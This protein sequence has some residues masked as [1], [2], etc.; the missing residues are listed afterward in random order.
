LGL[1]RRVV[2]GCR[3]V[4]GLYRKRELAQVVRE[5]TAV[6]DIGNEV[7]QA[8]KP[9]DQLKTDPEKARET[10]TFAANVC[11]ALA[12]YLWPIVP[13]FAEAAARGLGVTIARMDA[14]LLFAERQRQLGTFER[15]FERIERRQTDAVVEASKDSLAA[16]P[17]PAG[18][19]K[20]TP[21]PAGVRAGVAPAT[22]TAGPSTAAS[23]PALA[24]PTAAATLAVAA[25]TTA[26]TTATMTT[27]TT[28]LIDYALFSKLDLRVGVVIKAEAVP[29]SKKLLRLEVDLGEATLRQIVAGIALSYEPAA[30]VGTRI[31]VVANLEPVRLMGVES[32][33]M[34]L[35]AGEAPALS[36]LRL[37]RE[38]PPGTKVK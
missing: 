5:L 25:A 26:T 21:K 29:K 31:V 28:G 19:A 18:N 34:V 30:L 23:K 27:P 35:A 2:A 20:A 7:M 24:P 38:L 3:R 12:M 1:A 32:R 22:T 9:W 37:E 14:S 16:A 11:Y 10:L 4:E 15:L 6:A 13:R 17:S 33:G 8:A 36:L